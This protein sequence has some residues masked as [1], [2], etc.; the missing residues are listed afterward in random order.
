MSLRAAQFERRGRPKSIRARG[1]PV[2]TVWR[3][4]LRHYP[5]VRFPRRI[6]GRNGDRQRAAEQVQ[7]APDSGSGA[8]TALPQLDRLVS[9]MFHVKRSWRV[10]LVR[11]FHVKL[12]HSHWCKMDLA[13]PSGSTAIHR[14]PNRLFT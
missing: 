1:A 5:P 11:T 14:A 12:E 10:P 7:V 8:R 4:K 2:E 9:G 6:T 13:T 3:F